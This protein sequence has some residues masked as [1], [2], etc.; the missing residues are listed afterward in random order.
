MRNFSLFPCTGLQTFSLSF[1]ISFDYSGSCNALDCTPQLLATLPLTVSCV[2]LDINFAFVVQ[3]AAI[4]LNWV[5][6]HHALARMG[7]QLRRGKGAGEVKIIV[8]SDGM[9]IQEEEKS[10]VEMLFKEKFYSIR[11]ILR[12]RFS[13]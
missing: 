8:G 12:I 5:P 4:N 11:D 7:K 13:P 3:A 1:S 9:I 10:S 6:V 2:T